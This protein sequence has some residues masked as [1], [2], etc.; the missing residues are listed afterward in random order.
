MGSLPF[1]FSLG[2]KK[3]NPE[4]EV[5]VK[6]LCLRCDPWS[7]HDCLAAIGYSDLEN[8]SLNE[9]YHILTLILEWMAF[10]NINKNTYTEDNIA[11]DQNERFRTWAEIFL[12][13]YNGEMQEI[14]SVHKE[15]TG[16]IFT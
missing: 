5:Q 1:L 7:S 14:G 11:L 9:C 12:V 16:G 8:E 13:K 10:L 6:Y 15:T 2:K 3:K 4:T